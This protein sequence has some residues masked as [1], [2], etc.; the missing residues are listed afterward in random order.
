MFSTSF[1]SSIVI[2]QQLREL[3]CDW[4][5]AKWVTGGTKIQP[6]FLGQNKA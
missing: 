3:A 1:D 6:K 5:A 2:G 4:L